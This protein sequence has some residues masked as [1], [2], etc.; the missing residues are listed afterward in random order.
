MAINVDRVETVTF[1]SFSTLVDVDST[2]RAVEP[3]VDDPIDFARRWH[4]RAAVYG[5]IGNYIDAYETY[6]DLHLD[7]LEYLLAAEGVD[8]TRDELEKMNAVYHE[9]EPFDDV[10]SGIQQLIDAGYDVGVISNGDP[11]MLDSLVPS[12][13]STGCSRR[14]SAP[15]RSNATNPPSNCTNT[16]PLD[17]TLTSKRRC[18]SATASSTYRAPSTRGCRAS[19]STDRTRRRSRSV[20]SRISRS[21]RSTNSSP[22]WGSSYGPTASPYG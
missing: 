19:G 15:T 4:S 21:N 14:P 12:L 11:P 9:M 6:D 10:R 5:A 18:T 3:Y 2:A 8:V 22:G 16:P 20:R 17:S 7:A 13:I 1:D